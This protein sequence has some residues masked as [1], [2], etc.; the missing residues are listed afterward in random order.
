MY[1]NCLCCFFDSQA[2]VLVLPRVW[3]SC[4]FVALS[5]WHWL[6]SNAFVFG[7]FLGCSFIWALSWTSWLF[8]HRAP[9]PFVWQLGRVNLSTG[10]CCTFQTQMKGSGLKSGE[11]MRSPCFPPNLLLL[12]TSPPP[13]LRCEQAR[14]GTS[15][16]GDWWLPEALQEFLPAAMP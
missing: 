4:L 8:V 12:T 2:S 5:L 7:I 13:C 10:L 6:M 16:T 15:P 9:C 14:K 11:N 3:N 1:S